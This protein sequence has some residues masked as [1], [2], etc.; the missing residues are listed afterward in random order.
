MH[1]SLTNSTSTIMSSGSLASSLQ[2]G[3]CKTRRTKIFQ[4]ERTKIFPN[5]P[6]KDFFPSRRRDKKIFVWY[7]ACSLFQRKTGRVQRFFFMFGLGS[8]VTVLAS[9]TLTASILQP[10]PGAMPFTPHLHSGSMWPYS[11]EVLWAPILLLLVIPLIC[12]SQHPD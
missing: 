1:T 9:G 12:P 7:A 10:P 11:L 5:A 2:F 6:Y 4:T 8:W 3:P